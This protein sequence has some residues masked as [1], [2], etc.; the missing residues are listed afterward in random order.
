MNAVAMAIIPIYLSLIV[1]I[2]V[3][4]GRRVK[5]FKDYAMAGHQLPW[6]VVSGTILATFIGGGTML[7]F[8]GSYYSYGLQWFWM[9]LGTSL[10]HL[11]MAYYLAQRIRRFNLYTIADIFYKRYGEST[12]RIAG[13]INAIVGVA[14]GFAMLA[15][16]AA[17]LNGYVGIPTDISMLIGV[18][19]FAATATMGGL[20]GV[21]YTDAI[22]VILILA[23]A[24]VV[25][26]TSFVKAGGVAGIS[27]LPPNLLNPGSGNIPW[28]SYIAT[29]IASVGV[30]LADQATIF[31]RVN[32]TQTPRAARKATIVFAWSCFGVFLL[33]G[34]MGLSAR[35]IAGAGIEENNVVAELLKHIN[36]VFAALYAAAVIAAVLTTAN[37]MYLSAS[38]TFS[39]DLLQAV[40]PEISDKTMLRVSKIFVWIM[41][42]ISFF[43]IRFQPSIMRWIML[44]YTC[45]SCM[46]VPLY[47]GLL[48][49]KATPAS[50]FWSLVLSIASVIL[51]ELTGKP[52]GI[53]SMYVA[54]AVGILAFAVGFGSKTKSSKE[55]LD[56]VEL[57]KARQEKD[58]TD[59]AMIR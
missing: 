31:Q 19:L 47:G 16:F 24:I 51:W 36:P 39:R 26:I 43:V 4:T 57:F 35:V 59:A 23:G 41:A 22:Q 52:L 32:A 34:V 50:G 58:E 48:S 17:I 45:V 21:A 37:S 12:K 6:Y 53:D 11:F 25:G 28:F 14:V 8:V 40:K 20:V 2:I 15:G 46:I 18:I 9:C 1:L 30:G 29:I 56:M 3:Y 42:I 44:G 33:M 13:V 10:S 7:G 49:K 55:Q 54:L 38:M 27:T 5:S